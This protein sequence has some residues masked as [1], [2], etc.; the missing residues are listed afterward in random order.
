[1][2]LVT[3]TPYGVNSHRPL[4]RGA[5]AGDAVTA[6]QSSPQEESPAAWPVSFGDR[7]AVLFV[8]TVRKALASIAA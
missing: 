4:V 2:T 1:M 6:P 5:R 7:A 3:C 8:D